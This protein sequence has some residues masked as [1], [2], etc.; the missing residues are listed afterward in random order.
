MDVKQVTDLAAPCSQAGMVARLPVATQTAT[1]PVWAA[2]RKRTSAHLPRRGCLSLRP[3]GV[4]MNALLL[5]SGT[6][7][8][9][10][11]R[12]NNAYIVVP[13]GQDRLSLLAE[14][15]ARRNNITY[16]TV[17]RRHSIIPNNLVLHNC[18]I[19]STGS[20]QSGEAREKMRNER[21][22]VVFTDSVQTGAGEGVWCSLV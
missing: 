6:E 2:E 13:T 15:A 8:G 22:R 7:Q 11:R 10:L 1:E 16:S 21:A 12:G 19:F 3:V 17:C 9:I 20:A 5:S 14:E 18:N 4:T